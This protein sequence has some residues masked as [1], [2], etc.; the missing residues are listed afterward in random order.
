VRWDQAR[1][2]CSGLWASR[3]DRLLTRG[4]P[5]PVSVNLE[6]DGICCRISA[7]MHD[8]GQVNPATTL[9]TGLA[10]GM[11]AGRVR[12]RAHSAAGASVDVVTR[13]RRRDRRRLLP[14]A[15]REAAATSPP[16]AHRRSAPARPSGQAEEHAEHTE[17]VDCETDAEG[18]YSVVASSA[19]LEP[20]GPNGDLA[21]G[22]GPCG[23]RY[24]GSA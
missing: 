9:D 2:I 13:P 8:A 17:R 24:L 1:R 23:L 7:I 4:P 16:P 18:V 3:A 21:R 5:G 20:P 12:P 10:V 14:Q 6:E 22:G 19:H 11:A 15:A